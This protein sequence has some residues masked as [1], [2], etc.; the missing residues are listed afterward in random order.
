M[1][2][3]RE[4]LDDHPL[5]IRV[6]SDRP[7]NLAAELLSLPDVVSVE[8]GERDTLVVRARNPRN[9]FRCFTRLV[10]EESFDIRHL[11]PLDDTAQAILGYLLGS[12]R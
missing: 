7:R 11:E 9:F 1:T 10:L 2:Q 8:L 6:V 5:A 12:R 3:I 4:L